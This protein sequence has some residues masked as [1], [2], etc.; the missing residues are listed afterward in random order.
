MAHCYA[1]GPLGHRGLR[2]FDRRIRSPKHKAR[3]RVALWVRWVNRRT[4]N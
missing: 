3:W 4:C 1:L 2:W